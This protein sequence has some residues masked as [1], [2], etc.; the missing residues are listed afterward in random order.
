MLH[1][2][3][4]DTSLLYTGDFKLR[5]APTCP[6]ADP[7]P[8]DH[9]IM[10]CTYGLPHF[11]FPHPASVEDQLVDK[12]RQALAEGRQPI[13]YAYALGKAQHVQRVLTDRGLPVT[14]HGAV[15]NVSDKYEALGVPL[16]AYR[17][18]R[19]EDFHGSAAIPLPERGVLIAPPRNTRTPFTT[20]FERRWT[21]MLSGWGID[22]NA[23]YRY[24]VDD[25]LPLSDHA[26]HNE[27]W[28]TIDRV[29]P[30]VVWLQHGFV[31]EFLDELRSRGLDARPA[32][33]LEQ[34]EL[35]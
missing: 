34:L 25:V 5:P 18:Y 15:A 3:L 12:C 24:G 29:N 10:E 26:D 28:E 1:A 22:P 14:L 2:N 17:R 16:G 19:A 23:R 13:A 35:F 32:R 6:P 11:R 8:A 4:G 20:R 7:S 9:L 21:V 30:K 31:R 33:P 27:L